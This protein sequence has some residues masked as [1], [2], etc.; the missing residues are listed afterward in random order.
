MTPRSAADP[1]A[2][3]HVLREYA[4]LADGER[5]ALVGPRGDIGWLCAPRWD[6]GSVFSALIG[7]RGAY[8]VTPRAPHVWG[9]S[10]EPGTLIWH[11]RWVTHEGVVECREALGYPGEGN[12]VVLLRRV[13]AQCPARL[14]VLL[15]PRAD[16]D[17]SAVRRWRCDD[18]VWSGTTGPLRIRWSGAAAARPVG[19]GALAMELDVAAGE[20][21]D[22]VLEIVDGEFTD[23]PPEPDAAW[24]ATATAWGRAVPEFDAVRA[25]HDV[26]HSYAV[27]RGLTGAGGTVAAATTSLPER[28]GDDRNYDYRY[29]WMR[30][31]CLVGQA[32]AACGADPLLDVAVRVITERLLEHGD[33]LA[34]AYTVSG[35]PIPQQHHLALP[36]YP[37]G[38]DVVGN[39]VRDQFQL[40]V[41]GEALLLLAAAARHDRLDTRGWQ[42]AEVAVEAAGRSWQRPD[43][44]IWELEPR[45][46]THSRLIVAAGLRALAAARPRARDR[47]AGSCVTLADRIVAETARTALHADGCWQRAPDDPASDAA[48]VLA[49]LREAVPS[50]DP[51]TDATLQAYLR[52]LTVDGY[53]YRFRHDERPLHEAEGSFLLCGFATAL[54]LD[55]QGSHA[56]AIGWFERSRSACGPAG[57]FSEEYDALQHQMRGNLPQTFVHA[58]MIE[59]SAALAAGE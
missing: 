23:R 4:V 20:Q 1:Q 54:A 3:P 24:L 14:R 34:P 31:Q 42:A 48:L 33:K 2:A 11:S 21:H 9:G 18:G 32:A 13:I 50:G 45:A 43:A 55:Q 49:G 15:W 5:A 6:S 19:G 17:R 29:V 57:L 53:A 8:V 30:D 59:A 26:A 35:E 10:Y 22:L 44:G 37:G 16:Y 27:L 52:E 41:F 46:W 38:H 47:L 12:R 28:A 36:G 7:G 39:D 25:P 51:R 56:E 40:D 58:L